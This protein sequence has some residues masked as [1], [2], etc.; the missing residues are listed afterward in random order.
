MSRWWWVRL[1]RYA[2]PEWRGLLAILLLTLTGVGIS[3]L[4]PWPMKLIV[5]NV[6]GQVAL[7]GPAVWLEGLPGG[8]LPS[9]QLAWLAAA[10]VLLY[11]AQHLV[12][13]VQRYIQSGVGGRMMFGLARE[14]F[15]S[16]QHRSLPFHHRQPK[17]DL[18]R[19]I[20]VESQ[21]V[22]ELVF[23]VLLPFLTSIVTV[24]SMLGVMWQL[25]RPLSLFALALTVPLALVTRWLA[26][27]MS[28][29][30][31]KEWELQGEMSSLVEQTL[32]AIPIVQAFGR[33]Q[34][35]SHR[36]GHLAGQT[37]RATLRTE[38][39]QHQYRVAVNGVN[40]CAMALVMLYGGVTVLRG[41]L[42]VGSL[43]VVIAY[44]AAL[45]APIENMAYL[46][47][48]FSAASAGARR[49][50]EVLDTE[51]HAVR[52]IPGATPFPDPGESGVTV[53]LKDV[54]FAYQPGRPVL[55]NVSLVAKP[56]EVVA[57]VGHTGA[58]KSTLVSLLPRLFDPSGGVVLFNGRDIRTV[59]LASLRKLVSVVPQE[60]F[61]LPLSI[62]D[63]IAYARPD[64]TRNEVVAAAV[65]A[66][67]HQFIEKLLHGYDTVI[68][69]RGATLSGGEKQRL[70]I[71]RA[72]LT[73]AP[74][75]ILDEPTS[76]LDSDTESELLLALEHL[77]AGRTT[78]IIAHRPSTI[79][80]AEQ[81]VVLEC[82]RVVAR[83]G[84]DQLLAD[85]C[86]QLAL[87][88]SRPQ[89]T[90]VSTETDFVR[91]F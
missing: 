80:K 30:K 66:Q 9:W 54:S 79:R 26:G 88:Q 32:T 39:A 41:E 74:I 81:I 35:T 40:A 31:Y 4:S 90:S 56:G 61:L 1:A 70:S 28:Q 69:E 45:Y 8:S 11:F 12:T 14:L 68:G 10:T 17:G 57:L 73:D 44:F 21:C 36:F 27:P 43:L 89:R 52:D 19:R 15:D 25:S 64:A 71:A 86:P 13:V 53:E 34:D 16:L 63:N 24:L 7:S 38:V 22:H 83:G 67:A 50:F 49:V 18:V 87:T 6:L 91:P 29:W 46:S 65:A 23:G 75:L 20:T 51:D 84:Y 55:Q 78:F 72:L 37:V 2:S 82:G 48:S 77:M 85:G 76:A 5:D 62:A 47:E 58:G 3:L 60:P 33:E 59:Q 42:S